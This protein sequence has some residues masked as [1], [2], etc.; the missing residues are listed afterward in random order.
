MQT[1]YLLAM[2][3]LLVYFSFSFNF[4]FSRCLCEREVKF[5]LG[6]GGVNIVMVGTDCERGLSTTMMVKDCHMFNVVVVFFFIIQYFQNCPSVT[7]LLA[8][9][10][11]SELII[12]LFHYAT[13]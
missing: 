9:I 6:C 1:V 8:A 13:F 10:V 12:T 5:L 2:T 4:I 3:C 7:A 11:V